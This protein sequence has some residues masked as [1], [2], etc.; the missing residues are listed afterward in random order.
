VESGNPMQQVV[1]GLYTAGPVRIFQSIDAGEGSNLGALYEGFG[2]PSTV[3]EP[4]TFVLLGSAL[5]FL[6]IAGRRLRKD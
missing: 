1:P 4:I 5:A 2:D 3:P 6:G